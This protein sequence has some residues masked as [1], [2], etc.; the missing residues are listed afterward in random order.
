MQDNSGLQ[1][2]FSQGYLQS[3]GLSAADASQ[4]AAEIESTGGLLLALG[5]HPGA[6]ELIK[7]LHTNSWFK[8]SDLDTGIISNKGG[9]QGCKLGGLIFNLIYA[10]ALKVL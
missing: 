1:E 7:S 6:V 4:M 5:A 10:K 9:R 8:F 2:F 3:M